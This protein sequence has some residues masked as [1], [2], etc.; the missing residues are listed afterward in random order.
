MR[1][2]A[3]PKRDQE[4]PTGGPRAAHRGHLGPP[5]GCFQR[6]SSIKGNFRR[7]WAAPRA[8][9]SPPGG[10]RRAPCGPKNQEKRCTVDDFRVFGLPRQTNR[11]ERS[12]P[13]KRDPRGPQRSPKGARRGPRAAPERP[14][15]RQERPKRRPAAAQKRQRA[16]KE[17]Q[18]APRG[19]QDGTRRAPSGPKKR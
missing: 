14:K 12:R 13:A 9:R 3:Q 6:H 1:A 15:K 11:Q 5:R 17:L 16:A 4:G 10:A 18:R 7:H 8:T 2:S 19:S